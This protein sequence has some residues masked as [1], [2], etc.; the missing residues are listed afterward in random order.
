MNIKL[1]SWQIADVDSLAYYAN[2]AEIAKNLTNQFPHPY[3]RANAEAFIGFATSH[4]PTRI[5]AIDL[6][7][8]AIGGIGIHPQADV[9]EKNAELGYWLAQ[10]FWGRGIIT[11]AVE[12]IVPIAFETLPIQRLFAR[13]FGTNKASQKILEKNN[14]VLEAVFE[15]TIYKNGEYLDEWV[16]ARRRPTT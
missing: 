5:F 8:E 1:R 2:N 11:Q 6:D 9:F 7:G 10:P 13:P 14:F 12:L 4:T 15:K 3:T 16:Y